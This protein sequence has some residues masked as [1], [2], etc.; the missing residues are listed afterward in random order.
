MVVFGAAIGREGSVSGKF[1]GGTLANLGKSFPTVCPFF[2][3]WSSQPVCQSFSIHSRIGRRRRTDCASVLG[4]VYLWQSKQRWQEVLEFVSD[5]EK[6]KER[7]L[8]QN[9]YF[10]Y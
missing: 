7:V 3:A 1:S 4:K 6:K 8:L 2:L 9:L 10:G 5:L